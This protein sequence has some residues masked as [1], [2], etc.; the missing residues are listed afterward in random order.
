MTRTQNQTVPGHGSGKEMTYEGNKQPKTKH[1]P[2]H[3]TDKVPY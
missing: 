2:S 3:H 1:F